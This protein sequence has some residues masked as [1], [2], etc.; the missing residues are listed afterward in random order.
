MK[1]ELSL[2]PV[3][4]LKR[5]ETRRS[6]RIYS[7]EGELVAVLARERHEPIPL[8]KVAKVAQRALLAIEDHRFYSHAGTDWWG[9]LRAAGA[10][11]R[12]GGVAEGASTL[13]MQLA[14]RCFLNDDLSFWRKAREIALARR[15]EKAHSK[16][17]ILELYLNNVY[18]GAG[19]YG[20]EAASRGYFGIAAEQLNLAQASL[21]VGL[22]QS[23]SALCPFDHLPE[24]QERQRLVLARLYELNWISQ[25]QKAQA[26]QEKLAIVERPLRPSLF[27]YPYYTSYVVHLLKQRLGKQDPYEAGLE[28]RTGLEPRWQQLLERTLQQRLWE[29]IQGAAVLIHNPSGQIRALAG[30]RSFHQGDQFNRAW[31][32]RRQPGSCFKTFVYAAALSQGM[33]PDSLISDRPLQVGE[34]SPRNSDGAFLGQVTLRQAFSQSRNAASVQLALDVG[35]KNVIALAKEVGLDEDLPAHPSLALGSCE[36]SPLSIASAYSTF[37]RGGKICHPYAILQVSPKLTFPPP[38]QLQ[39]YDPKLNLELRSLLEEVVRSGTGRAASLAGLRAAGKTGTTDD[40]RDAW[41]VGFTPNWTL[42]IWVGRDDHQ[43]LGSIYG[44]DLPAQMWAEIM[45]QLP[46]EQELETLM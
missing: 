36:V 23:P 15:I 34:W 42:A 35:L 5:F 11:F 19:Y 33:T 8:K 14:R 7:R 38:I 10:N 12:R 43:S 22:V 40:N 32:A 37:A 41:F 13:T 25:P 26:E 9:G 2:P 20:I 28:V 16:D 39:V 29:P 27:K 17:K 1:V 21:L 24:A 6:T 30:G 31:Q 3:T 4:Q 45:S 18:F 46:Q 44:G